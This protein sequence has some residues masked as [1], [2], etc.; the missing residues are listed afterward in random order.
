MH[1]STCRLS[2]SRETFNVPFSEMR[3][4]ST[5]KIATKQEWKCGRIASR[6]CVLWESPVFT[7]F[8]TS[9]ITGILCHLIPET[10]LLRK[11]RATAAKLCGKWF[12]TS[13]I[14]SYWNRRNQAHLTSKYKV[15]G[16]LLLRCFDMVS[17]AVA[18]EVEKAS[19]QRCHVVDYGK[20]QFWEGLT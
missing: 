14:R 17:K 19:L 5:A 10:V 1:D 13:Y 15:E 4:F 11:R 18:L 6:V 12:A 3:K 9:E 2:A 8:V 16:V 20:M 7:F